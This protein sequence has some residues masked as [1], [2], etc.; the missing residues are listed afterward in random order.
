MKKFISI[1]LVLVLALSL[2]AGCG[3]DAGGVKNNGIKS[4]DLADSSDTQQR[5]LR[6]PDS[7][8]NT[9]RLVINPD[10]YAGGNAGNYDRL[11]LNLGLLNDDATVKKSL[12]DLIFIV[13]SNS[14]NGIGGTD[15]F[16]P[17]YDQEDTENVNT[18]YTVKKMTLDVDGTKVSAIIGEGDETSTQNITMRVK[19]PVDF[20]VDIVAVVDIV[21]SSGVKWKVTGAS[22]KPTYSILAQNDTDATGHFAFNLTEILSQQ[23][24]EDD[25]VSAMTL[26]CT[27]SVIG[28]N[29]P[30]VFDNY[31]IV[32]IERG[33][34][35]ADAN[36]STTWY[37]YG[38]VSTLTYPNGTAAEV[39]DYFADYSTVARRIQFTADGSFYLAGKVYGTLTY[40]EKQNLMIIEGDGFNYVVS[41]KRKQYVTFYNSEADLLARVNGTEEP[42]ADTQYWTV[43]C[44]RIEVG[45]D[46]YVSVALDAN[47]SVEELCEEAKAAVGAGNTAKRIETNI[48][49]WDAYLAAITIPSDLILASASAAE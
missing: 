39:M 13:E 46:L 26:N 44:G 12:N 25:D 5:W 4:K 21:S 7:S 1:M 17:V 3:G 49:Y 41:P 16:V 23:L 45:S 14:A 19:I 22:Q 38:I 20:S 37:P 8:S 6:L 11:P 31:K 35:Y 9:C 43:G 15:T 29:S 28:A 33:F 32:T 40:D 36:A 42:T 30:L 24:K 2:L 48:E 47:K 10:E 27:L 18:R 34:Q